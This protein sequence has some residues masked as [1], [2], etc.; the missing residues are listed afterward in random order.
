M[1]TNTD[2]ILILITSLINT[3]KKYVAGCL[4]NSGTKKLSWAIMSPEMN[5]EYGLHGKSECTKTT[6]INFW[7]KLKWTIFRRYLYNIYEKIKLVMSYKFI[8]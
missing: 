3:F 5:W 8:T 4:R 7:N 6:M 1:L 2:E